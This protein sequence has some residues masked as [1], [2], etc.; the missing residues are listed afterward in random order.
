MRQIVLIAFTLLLLGGM[1]APVGAQSAPSTPAASSH[2]GRSVTVS[3]DPGNTGARGSFAVE[4]VL[5]MTVLSLA[6]AI[7]IML[8]SFTRIVVV[9]S[10]LRQAL[11]TQ[12][13]PPGQLIIGLSLFLTM[14]VMMPVLRQINDTALQP[15]L[16]D[17]I[18]QKTAYANAV[19]PLKAFM[20]TQTREKDLAMFIRMM[21]RDKPQNRESLGMDVVVPGFIISELKTA[22]IMGFVIFIPFV[23]I[24]MVVSSVLMSMG[25]LMLPPVMISLPFKLL[26]FVLV[27]G[28]NLVVQSLLS[29]FT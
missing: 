10:F 1:A 17:T 5:I 16:N 8:T 9:M 24:D 23:V 28:W 18:S 14:V 19:K 22:F 26:L 11:G 25:M 21:K 29:S 6:P 3:L 27:D 7:L 13:M 15:Y 4:I 2:P 20:L 12:Q